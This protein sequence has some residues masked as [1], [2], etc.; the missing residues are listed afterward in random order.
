MQAEGLQTGYDI[1]YP[2]Y[3]DPSM[4]AWPHI[5]VALEWTNLIL[6]VL[7]FIEVLIRAVGLRVACFMDVWNYADVVILVGW[8]VELVG[9]GTGTARVLRP[10]RL[11]RAF[12]F[13]RMIKYVR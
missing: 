6:G 8:F 2:N 13:L 5:V 4:G 1:G 11:V 12:R 7:F 9:V 3:E 10:A